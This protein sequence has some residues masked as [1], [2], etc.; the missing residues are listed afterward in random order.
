[1]VRHAKPGHYAPKSAP[2]ISQLRALED[3]HRT[4]GATTLRMLSMRGWLLSQTA[5]HHSRGGH[6][7]AQAGGASARSSAPGRRPTR[8]SAG[9]VPTCSRAAEAFREGVPS[10]AEASHAPAARQWITAPRCTE[11]AVRG[12]RAAQEPTSYSRRRCEASAA[13]GVGGA[14]RAKRS[15]GM[16]T[17][18]PSI[19]ERRS[20]SAGA[21]LA[22][23]RRPTAPGTSPSLSLKRQFGLVVDPFCTKLPAVRSAS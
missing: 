6:R 7:D 22:P 12:Q 1:M 20:C 10:G 5:V 21:W 16:T 15:I 4:V 3:R 8:S 13:R 2:T 9:C 17:F 23:L 14:P 11:A 18:R 19:G